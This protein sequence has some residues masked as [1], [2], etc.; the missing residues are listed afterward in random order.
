[1]KHND[2]LNGVLILLRRSLLQYAGEAW[3]WIG[4]G[5]AEP[6]EEVDKLIAAQG[7]RVRKL[8][9]LLDARR[10]TI[11][12]GAFRDFTDLHYLSLRFVLPHLVDNERTIVR[13][14]EL[15]LPA[16]AGDSE[17]T[18]LVAETLVAESQALTQLEHL[19]GP[20]LSPTA[21]SAA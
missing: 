17:A 1:M 9:D 12:F 18:A 11:D 15:A 16:C 21:Q 19:A 5:S 7:E 4:S 6:R 2:V 20:K 3:P 8:A 13:E 10:W 14:I